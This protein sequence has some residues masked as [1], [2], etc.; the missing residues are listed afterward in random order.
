MCPCVSCANA[1]LQGGLDPQALGGPPHPGPELR[2][3][4]PGLL[5]LVAPL[6]GGQAVLPALHAPRLGR[7]LLRAPLR[8]RAQGQRGPLLHGDAARS[9]HRD[10]YQAST[11][12]QRGRIYVYMYVQYRLGSAPIKP[13]PRCSTV[14][15]DLYQASTATMADNIR[16]ALLGTNDD[17][18]DFGSKLTSRLCAE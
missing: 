8:P 3:P 9:L 17:L 15:G 11:H 16:A 18:D 12:C 10:V 4:P 7:H 13:T 5:P 14:H 2:G 6:A 1:S